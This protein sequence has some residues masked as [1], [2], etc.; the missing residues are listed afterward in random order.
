MTREKYMEKAIQVETKVGF[1]EGRDAIHLDK[2]ESNGIDWEF[3]GE[4]CGDL[5]T[6]NIS[7]SEW[8]PYK[9]TFKSVQNLFS[10]DIECEPTAIVSWEEADDDMSVFH[11]IE[12]S[13]FLSNIPIRSEINRNDL[14]HYWLQTYDIAFHIIAKNYDLEL[15]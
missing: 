8:I 3:V 7:K 5:V 1:I 10:C 15:L 11:F 9:L 14:K 12:N 13:K 4:F 6:N 2:I